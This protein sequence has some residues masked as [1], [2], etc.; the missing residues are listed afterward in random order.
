MTRSLRM[1][2]TVYTCPGFGQDL[3][4][5]DRR[6]LRQSRLRVVP[7]RQ[8]T[9]GTVKSFLMPSEI[10]SNPVVKLIVARPIPNSSRYERPNQGL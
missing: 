5:A 8:P 4:I 9:Y 6:V 2:L 7:M 1:S 3:L 10:V